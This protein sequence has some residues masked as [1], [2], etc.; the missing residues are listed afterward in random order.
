MLRC[1]QVTG[2]RESVSIVLLKH[3]PGICKCSSKHVWEAVV[4]RCSVHLDQ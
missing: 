2:C 1:V 4:R 3:K